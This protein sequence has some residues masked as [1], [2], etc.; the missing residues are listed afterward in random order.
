MAGKEEMFKSIEGIGDYGDFSADTLHN[1]AFIESSYGTQGMD[2]DSTYAGPFQMGRGEFAEF[3][4]STGS[5]LDPKE[6]GKATLKYASKNIKDTGSWK[7]WG[8]NQRLDELGIEK[9]LGAYIT[10]QQGRSG[11]IDMITSLREGGTLGKKTRENILGNI[12]REEGVNFSELG[13]KDLVKR[14]IG[15]YKSKW[16]KAGE[17]TKG[18]KS[19]FQS[20]DSKVF[21]MVAKDDFKPSVRESIS[22]VTGSY[23]DYF[24]G[25][26]G[27]IPD[28]WQKKKS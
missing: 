16:K 3:G 28:L 2:I 6:A 20:T 7:K 14:F 23:K 21:D 24:K 19:K 1:M 25:K 17:H 13:D 27:F 12:S 10:H 5:R 4:G 11:T 8:M 9:G 15:Q 18:L 22:E 26:Q